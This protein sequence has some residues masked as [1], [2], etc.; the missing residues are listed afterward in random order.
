[1]EL[2]DFDSKELG[3]RLALVRKRV[4]LS[5]IELAKQLGT[6]QHMISKVENG[7]QVMTAMLLKLLVFYSKSISLDILFSDHFDDQYG[8]LE[9]SQ[10]AYNS[11]VRAKLELLRDEL[12]ASLARNQEEIQK[13][14]NEALHLL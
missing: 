12:S 3:R 10:Q 6:T 2:Q 4:G 7:M 1:M 14:V 13:Q 11:M 9:D 5:Q 8:E